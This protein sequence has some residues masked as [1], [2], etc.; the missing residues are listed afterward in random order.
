MAQGRPQPNESLAI[1]AIAAH[2]SYLNALVAWE[3]ALHAMECDLC[4]PRDASADDL[5]EI[6]D[7][8]EAEKE[9]RRVAFRN[10]TAELGCIPRGEGIALPEQ[11]HG[12]ACAAR[13]SAAVLP[14][15]P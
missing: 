2:H 9:R 1:R 11:E 14:S 10:L 5:V 4:R 7:Q 13:A 8:A 12:C 6:A 15:R 3:H